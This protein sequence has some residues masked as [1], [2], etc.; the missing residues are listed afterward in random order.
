MLGNFFFVTSS[1]ILKWLLIFPQNFTK[2]KSKINFEHIKKK[3]QILFFT[4]RKKWAWSA[5]C[6]WHMNYFFRSFNAKLVKSQLPKISG[7]LLFPMDSYFLKCGIFAPP[8][9]ERIG[10]KVSQDFLKILL[11]KKEELGVLGLANNCIEPYFDKFHQNSAKTKKTLRCP[12]SYGRFWAY[13][14]WAEKPSFWG[15]RNSSLYP[16]LMVYQMR[17]IQSRLFLISELHDDVI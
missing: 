2:K 7:R 1:K 13:R 6:T 17:E 15:H 3:I 8:P 14:F 16:Y 10:L 12:V 4:V 9:P 5:T 11:R